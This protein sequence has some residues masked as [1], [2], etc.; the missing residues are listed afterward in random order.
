[1]NDNGRASVTA[2]GGDPDQLTDVGHR[3]YEVRRLANKW[4][5]NA[6]L[7]FVMTT[8]EPVPGRELAGPQESVV[9]G[10][11][12]DQAPVHAGSGSKLDRRS[13]VRPVSLSKTPRVPEQAV[14]IG[15][16]PNIKTDPVRPVIRQLWGNPG[17]RADDREEPLPGSRRVGPGLPAE[18]SSV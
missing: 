10:G 16:P 1:M 3:H 4:G 7:S 5:P 8:L 17:W 6:Q 14:L 18:I 9:V 2:P 13:L 12:P 11:V 15:D